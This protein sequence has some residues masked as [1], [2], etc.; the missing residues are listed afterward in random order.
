MFLFLL[1]CFVFGIIMAVFGVLS[2]PS[3]QASTIPV[4]LTVQGV[5]ICILFIILFCGDT[6]TYFQE[7]FIKTCLSDGKIIVQGR[8]L[9]SGLTFSFLAIWSSTGIVWA[10][11]DEECPGHLSTCALVISIISVTLAILTLLSCVYWRFMSG[12]ILLDLE[13][14][15][16]KQTNKEHHKHRDHLLM[17]LEK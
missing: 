11:G 8:M 9:M 3:C 14:T 5:T 6:N 12:P 17:M 7:R 13:Q 4:W 2:M 15:Q 16:R 1:G 10:L